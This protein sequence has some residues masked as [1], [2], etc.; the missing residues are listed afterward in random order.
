MDMKKRI[1]SLVLVLV[2]AFSVLPIAAEA[3]GTLSNFGKVNTYQ[4]GQFTDVSNE[5]FAPS[6]QAAY[7]YGLMGGTSGATFSPAKNLT[8]AEAL[9]IAA[10]LHSIY[11]TGAASFPQADPWWQPYVDYALQNG[12]IAGAF[13]N[14]TANATRSDFAVIFA[15]ALPDEALTVRN[16]ID[17][18]AIPDVKLSYSYGPAVYKL[19]RAG[20]LTGSDAAGTFYPSTYITRDAVAAIV[21][22]MAVPDLRKTLTLPASA[23]GAVVHRDRR[24]MLPGSVLHRGLR[25]NRQG[26]RL[27]QRLLYKRLRQGCHEFSRD[28]RRLFGENHDVRRENLRCLGSL[29]FQ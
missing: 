15:A 23:E 29:R 16:T 12:I 1:L 4:A 2:L 7:E 3:A 21:A 27:R 14:Y 20:I 13:A 19:Y 17:D 26:F 10:C 6:V 5:W 8:V 25:F 9:K 28:R 11:N 22:R 18:N 24:Q